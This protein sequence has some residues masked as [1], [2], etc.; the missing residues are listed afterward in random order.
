MTPFDRA[1]K[2]LERHSKDYEPG[3]LFEALQD[4]VQQFHEAEVEATR[5]TC[6]DIREVHWAFRVFSITGVVL[7]LYALLHMGR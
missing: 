4:L 1:R 3:V 2:F 6:R 7:G 5:R